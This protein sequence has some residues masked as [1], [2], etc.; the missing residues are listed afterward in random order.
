MWVETTRKELGHWELAA[1][2]KCSALGN[3]LLANPELILYMRQR[4]RTGRAGRGYAT[5]A[6][7]PCHVAEPH[8][9]QETK[10]SGRQNDRSEQTRT[11]GGETARRDALRFAR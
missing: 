11:G 4:W 9:E 2:A 6:P 1:F 5:C 8:G 3:L 7:H 10:A